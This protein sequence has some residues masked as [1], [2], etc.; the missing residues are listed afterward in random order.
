M[1]AKI[2]MW[3]SQSSC[4]L[5]EKRCALVEVGH[6]EVQVSDCRGRRADDGRTGFR[7]NKDLLP[8]RLQSFKRHREVPLLFMSVN[9][10]TEQIL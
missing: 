2:S 6:C 4:N 5:C 7:G 10:E 8:S 1:E 9:N 3:D